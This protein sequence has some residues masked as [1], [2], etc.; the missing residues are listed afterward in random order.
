MM[1]EEQ[2]RRYWYFN[3]AGGFSVK[4]ASR[5]VVE[6]IRYTAELLGNKNNLVLMFPQGKI[7]SIHQQT[8]IFE[9]GIES[10]LLRPPLF[11]LNF[12]A[13]L[14][15]YFSKK[16]HGLYFYMKDFSGDNYN[17]LQEEY[18]KFYKDCLTQQ[19]N[20][21]MIYMAWSI[22]LF[23]SL[24]LLVSRQTFCF[25]SVFQKQGQIFPDW[26]RVSWCVTRKKNW[27]SFKRF[28]SAGLTQYD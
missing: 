1:L 19:V 12:L 6:T 13:C 27:K 21:E 23:E 10:I 7:E 15:D 8:F 2:L 16:K 18:N 20:I 22:L 4:K 3:Y 28:N 24:R 25:F 14:T 11:R 26:F 9:K 17:N 5:S